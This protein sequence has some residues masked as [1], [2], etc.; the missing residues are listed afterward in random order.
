MNALEALRTVLTPALLRTIV[1][2]VDAGQIFIALVKGLDSEEPIDSDGKDIMVRVTDVLEDTLA[3]AKLFVPMNILFR[4][5]RENETAMVLQPR[6]TNSPGSPYALYGDIGADD[7]VPP[8]FG[9]DDSGLFAKENLR[10]H[11]KENNVRIEAEA[12]AKKIE[13]VAGDTKITVNVGDDIVIEVAS[14]K[15]VLIGAASGTQK[16]PHGEDQ[17]SWLKGNVEAAVN[18]NRGDLGGVVKN[19]QHPF[20]LTV[21]VLGF[22]TPVSGTINASSSLSGLPSAS[23]VP[24]PPDLSDTVEAS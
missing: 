22:P 9:N 5:P 15:K 21:P 11:S 3:T 23:E 19:H 16:I 18:A 4:K 14:G 2:A 24:D 1:G 20:V 13:I 17:Q 7:A 12:S 10:V 8:W 6:D